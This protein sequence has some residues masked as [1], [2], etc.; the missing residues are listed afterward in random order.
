MV[1]CDADSVNCRRWSEIQGIA[2]VVCLV[3]S[4]EGSEVGVVGDVKD[5][6]GVE[7]RMG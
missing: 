6:G 2:V 5:Y 1:E 4:D 3:I 7:E